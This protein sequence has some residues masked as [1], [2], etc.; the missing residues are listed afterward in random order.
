[1]IRPATLEDLDLLVALENRCFSGDR[2]SRRSFRHLLTKGHADTLVDVVGG[3]L[4]GYAMLLYNRGTSLARLYSM[5]VAPELLRQGVGAGLMDAVETA[6]RGR[7][8]VLLR[9]EVRRDNTA[10]I[11]LYQKRGYREFGLYP[12]YYEDHMAALRFEKR[13]APGLAPPSR[14][15][16]Y[17]QTL[18]FT[19]GPAALMMAMKGLD[20]DLDLSRKLE[21]RLWRESTTVFMTSGHGGCGPFGLALAAHHRGFKVEI[22]V[23]DEGALF[24]DSVRSEEKKEVMR[25]VHEDF[26]EEIARVGIPI[27]L[28]TL[29]T[30]ELQERFDRGDIP[31][32]LISSYRIY[33]E[34]FPHWVVVTGFDDRFVYVHDPFIDWEQGKAQ[35]DCAHM[36]ILRRDFEAMARY[37]KGLLRAVLILHKDAPMPEL[38][39]EPSPMQPEKTVATTPETQDDFAGWS[40][41]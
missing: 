41:E 35:P 11:A 25:L 30:A 33:R 3:D 16:Y 23:N 21:L 24:L 19:C 28:G 12:D 37:G 20:P 22:W 9:L 13:L 5:A 10:A 2:I 38:F 34:K 36:P 39:A 32:V 27:H 17:E 18:E 29:K 7:D 14:I 1:M 40:E 6:A 26:V 8:C 15:P 4:R 31:V